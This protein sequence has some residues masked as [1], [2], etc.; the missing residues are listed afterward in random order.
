[1]PLG[2]YGVPTQT[3][4]VNCGVK[5]TNQDCVSLSV[6]PVL[7]ATGRLSERPPTAAAVPLVS[8]VLRICAT[9]LAT[10][11]VSALWHWPAGAGSSLLSLVVMVSTGEGTQ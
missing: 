4:V 10:L 9:P 3:A 2:L 6:V 8:T 5:P 7:P 1:M 11:G